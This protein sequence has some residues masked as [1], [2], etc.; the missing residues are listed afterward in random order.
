MSLKAS[1]ASRRG[2]PSP[3]SPHSPRFSW[4]YARTHMFDTAT[5]VAWRLERR[6]AKGVSKWRYHGSVV[7]PW[8]SR[9][10]TAL[11]SLMTLLGAAGGG[12]TGADAMEPCTFRD[13]EA[14]SETEECK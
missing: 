7:T 9:K 14:P 13:G 11:R 3:L 4:N 6:S 2:N 10:Y 8:C 12:S 5:G 1:N